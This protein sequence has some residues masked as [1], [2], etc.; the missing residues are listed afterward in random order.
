MRSHLETLSECPHPDDLL[1]LARAAA[2]SGKTE[3][4]IRDY[5]QRKRIGKYDPQGQRIVIARSGELRVSLTELQAF[6]REVDARAGQHLPMGVDHALG[7]Y[8]VPE[9][10]RTKHVHRLHPYLGKFIPQLVEQFLTQ[11]FTAGDTILDPFMG[12]GTTLVQ[13]NELGMHSIGFDVS[14]W[15]CIIARVKLGEYDLEQAAAEVLDAEQRTAEFSATI[16]EIPHERLTRSP[17]RYLPEPVYREWKELRSDYLRTWFAPRALAEILFYRSLISEYG[18]QDLLRVVLSR[19]V[20]SS[21]LIPHFDL[22]TP[23]VPLPVGEL[24]Y[25]RKHGRECVPIDNC[26]TKLHAYS[27]DTVRRLETFGA[28]RTSAS[29]TVLEADATSSDVF[30]LCGR[31]GL[32][33][34][35]EPFLDGI[36]TSPPYVGQIDYHDQHIYAYELFDLPRRDTQEIGPKRRGKS[37]AAQREY[38]DGIVRA[39]TNLSPALKPNAKVFLVA[40]DRFNLYP[41]IALR[42]GFK[43]VDEVKR[44]VTKRTEQGDDPYQESIF[45]LRQAAR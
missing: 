5:I 20:R 3:H 45:Q 15:N 29:A 32:G 18:Y 12:S 2:A 11:H 8:D 22:A 30:G 33:G 38:Q 17:K 36:F 40:N 43:I 13:A 21:R 10:E 7:F 39:L 27:A 28:V 25:C 4:N 35:L 24:Y 1:P 41:D 34:H 14:P 26:L 9:R 42:S 23:R 31:H 37:R 44:A 19:A 6:L 16:A